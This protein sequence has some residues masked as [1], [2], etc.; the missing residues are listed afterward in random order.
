LVLEPSSLI[1]SQAALWTGIIPGTIA[2][3]SA[4]IWAWG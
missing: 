4:L 2:A 3:R 1:K